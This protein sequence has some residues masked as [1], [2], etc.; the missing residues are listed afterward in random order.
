MSMEQK[1]EDEAPDVS[2][3]F[4]TA[5]EVEE[6]PDGSRKPFCVMQDSRG[7]YTFKWPIIAPTT[8]K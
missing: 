2:R 8:Y 1:N 5:A 3:K 4:Q 7:D 6:A